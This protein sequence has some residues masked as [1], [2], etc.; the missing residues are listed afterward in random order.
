VVGG[1]WA[2]SHRPI[3][4]G[5]LL[6]Q[7]SGPLE[8]WSGVPEGHGPGGVVIVRVCGLPAW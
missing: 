4:R 5:L 6:R 7:T 1:R 8:S 3:G 2:G